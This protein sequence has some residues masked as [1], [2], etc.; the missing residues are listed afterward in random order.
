MKYYVQLLPF[1]AEVHWGPS[2]YL[3]DHDYAD[4]FCLLFS[5]ALGM[6]YKLNDLIEESA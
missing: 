3:E 2:E 5:K 6:Q 1:K 4:V